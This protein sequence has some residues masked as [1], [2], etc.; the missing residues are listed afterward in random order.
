MRRSGVPVVTYN[1]ERDKVSRT[2]S[3][4]PMFEGGLVL[5]MNIKKQLIKPKL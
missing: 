1:P 5:I 4:A 2:H 3:V